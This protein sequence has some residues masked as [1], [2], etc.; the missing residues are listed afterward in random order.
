MFGRFCSKRVHLYTGH[1]E[2]KWLDISI[3]FT[4]VAVK[5]V[6]S[7]ALTTSCVTFGDWVVPSSVW[8][9]LPDLSRH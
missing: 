3:N 2:N 7:Y 6:H 5:V 9:M 8:T 1:L 4:P